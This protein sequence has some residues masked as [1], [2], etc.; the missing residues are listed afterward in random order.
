MVTP[1][2]IPISPLSLER[3]HSYVG[4]E[5]MGE[6]ARM[7]DSARVL[8][9]GRTV[10]NINSTAVGGGVAELLPWLLG[11]SRGAGVD[12]RWLVIEGRA[13]FFALTKR[14]HHAIHGS[15]GDGRPLDEA[16]HRLYE[17]V[18][19]ENAE[20]LLGVVRPGDVVILH[21]PQTAGLAP[22]L[23][24]AGARVMWR[25]HIG[26][27]DPNAESLAGWAFLARYL[28]GVGA[29]IF[30]RE[31]YR[32]P[33]WDGARSAV[34]APSIDPFTA[35]NEMLTPETTRALLQHVGIIAGPRHDDVHRFG[36][37]DGSPR[38]VARRAEV[39]RWGPAPGWEDPLVV[40]VSRWD[41]LKDPVGVMRGFAEHLARGGTPADL[42]LAGPETH[43]VTDDPEAATTLAATIEEWR[44][45]PGSARSRIHLVSL[46]VTDVEENAAVVNALQRHA[47]VIVQKSLHEGFGLTVTEAMWKGRAVLASGVGGIRDQIVDGEHGLLLDDPTDR[48][49]FAS[50]LGRLLAEPG[51]A[52][53]LGMRARERV[54]ERFLA[55]RHL[56]EYAE[57][58]DRLAGGSAAAAGAE[59]AGG[60]PDLAADRA[61]GR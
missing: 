1:R 18:L 53:R 15:P 16:A 21:D 27:E 23:V 56:R 2:E 30:S 22:A 19:R 7:A 57:L 14:L 44:R 8:L 48:G 51:L 39:L 29:Y 40:Q 26:M 37:Q 32:P 20:Y 3:L 46:P 59:A 35:K 17:E 55:P 50:K 9:Q 52:R 24:A 13:E 33:G 38:S 12:A 31:G 60:A 42:V 61:Q 5:R 49:E 25:S 45:L 6:T 43:A 34:I 11:Y 41:P 58:L 47:T 36:G 10:W 4:A 28:E 54:I